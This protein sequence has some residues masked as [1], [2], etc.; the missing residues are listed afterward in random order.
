MDKLTDTVFLVDDDA[1]VLT[2][3]ARLLGSAGWNIRTYRS[4]REF[5]AEHD[6]SVSG[7][8]VLDLLMPDMSGLDLQ[9]ELA[10][11]G[12]HRPIVFLSGQ[13]D[14]PSSV[15]AMKSGAVD[16]LMKPVDSEIL[17]AAV[18][19][20]MEYDARQRAAASRT[21]GVRMRLSSLTARE[22]QVLDGVVAGL[23]NK[24][25][26]GRLGIVEKTVKVHRARAVAKLG[27]RS[28]AELVRMVQVA[29]DDRIYGTPP[30]QFAEP[31]LYS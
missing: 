8:L 14:V 3:I 13:G 9:K 12:H 11:R 24:Q 1:R 21:C 29:V 10:R 31:V 5:L 18:T 2:A 17:L 23:L 15:S 25:I 30:V 28:T 6:C 20:A 19:N 4:A 22:R 16:F 26:A 27:V 7:C